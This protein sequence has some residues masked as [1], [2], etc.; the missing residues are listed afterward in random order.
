VRWFTV[1][2]PK[3]RAF[4][5]AHLAGPV[6][7]SERK[8]RGT[9]CEECVFKYWHKDELYCKGANGGR[10]CG[11]GHWRLSRLTH[12]LWL[13]AMPCPIGKFPVGGV[14]GIMVKL[15]RAVRPVRS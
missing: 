14:L 2:Y 3:L 9:E 8:A 7:P 6:L 1:F 4:T 13:A 12:K 10:G 15:Y 5:L 11:C